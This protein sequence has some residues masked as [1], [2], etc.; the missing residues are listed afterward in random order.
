MKGCQ[1]VIS[2]ITGRAAAARLVDGALDDLLVAPP[3]DRP[4]PGAIYRARTERPLKGL[5][6]IFVAWP[7]GRGFLR[8]AKGLRPGETLL[9]QVTGFAEPGKAAPVTRRLLFKSRFCILTP[10]APGL[11]ISRAI[12]DEDRRDALQLIAHEAGLPDRMGAI[13]RSAAETAA[14][15]EIE[16]DVLATAEIARAVADDEGTEPELLLDGPDPARLAWRD[17]TDAEDVVEG[18][19]AFGDLDLIDR[20]EALRSPDVALGGGAGMAV[21]ATRALVAIDVNTGADGSPAAGLKASIAAARAMP[22]ALRLRG[23]GGQITIDFAPFPKKDRRQLETVLR[24][25]FRGDPIDT[26]L[27]GWTPLGHFELQRKRERISLAEA[28][29]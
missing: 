3:D 9:V 18:A 24:A 28:L 21:E 14:E 29:R 25:A 2:E 6:G 15:T 11:N 10:E 26:T 27:V 22:T 4:L 1:I 19:S 13:I 12:K 17:W 23:L 20:I 7:G 16:D 8:D 5:G